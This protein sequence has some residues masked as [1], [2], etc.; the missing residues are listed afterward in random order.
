MRL[1]AVIAV[2]VGLDQ[3]TKYL[4]AS[5]MSTGQTVTVI[6]RL[7]YLTYIQNPGAAFGLLPYRTIFFIAITLIVMVFMLIYYRA[8]PKSFYIMRLGLALQ[9]GGALGNLIDRLRYG[10]VIDFIDLQFFPPVFNLADSAI[11]I[12]VGMFII[13]FWRLYPYLERSS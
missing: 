2:V 5:F 9:L 13:A 6:P 8:L 10:Q 7:L 3:L 4:I 1:L 11:V 12:G